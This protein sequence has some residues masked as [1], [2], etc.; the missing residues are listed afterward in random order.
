MYTFSDFKMQKFA[1]LIVAECNANN[2]KKDARMK[3]IKSFLNGFVD[4]L[5][6]YSWISWLVACRCDMGSGDLIINPGRSR[7]GLHNSLSFRHETFRWKLINA[8]G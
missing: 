5:G 7:K 4:G 6:F 2:T 1:D 8:L 3:K